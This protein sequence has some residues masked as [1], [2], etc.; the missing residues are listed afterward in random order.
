[1]H[2]RRCTSTLFR[3]RLETTFGMSPILL[4]LKHTWHDCLGRKP[5]CLLLL[6][7]CPTN[8]PYVQISSSR[9]IPSSVITAPISMYA[10]Q[11]GS[12]FTPVLRSSQ[13]SRPM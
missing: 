2:P 8:W 7:Q 5:P 1:F 4:P 11:A 10:R 9:R 3:L 13:L 12:L 6:V